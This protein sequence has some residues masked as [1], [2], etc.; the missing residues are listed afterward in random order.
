MSTPA[1]NPRFRASCERG[2]SIVE[3]VFV[4]PFLLVLLF[5]IV[6]LGM[7][8]N[9]AS[10]LNHVAANMSRQLAVANPEATGDPVAYAKKIA[11]K[12]VRDNSSLK[13][14]VSLPNGSTPGTNAA[15]CVKLSMDRTVHVIPGFPGLGPKISMSGKAANKLEMPVS[16][17]G[18]T[19]GTG[20]C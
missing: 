17:T 3:F 5:G 12:S 9:N 6:D 16:I 2:Q 18:A 19:S 13:V 10:D 11:E 20:A 14:D 15:V 1:R 7:A 4:L 8:V